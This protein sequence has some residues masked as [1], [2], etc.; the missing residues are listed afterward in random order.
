MVIGSG[1]TA[2]TMIPALAE[3]AE[4]VTMLQRSPTYIVAGPSRDDLSLKLHRHLPLG[5]AAPL[6]RWRMILRSLFYFQVARRRPQETRA[7]MLAGARA[8]L[9]PDFDVERHFAPRYN[10]WDQ[11]VCL[12]P[13]ADLFKAIK[14]GRVSV[15]TDEIERFVEDGILLKSGETLSADIIITA[16]GLRMKI[17]HGIEILVDGERVKLGNTTSYKGMMYSGIPNLASAFGYTNASWTL[18]AELICEYVCRLLNYMGRRG[19]AQCRPRLDEALFET[20]AYIDFSSGY[21]KRALKELPKQGTRRPWK[22]YQNYL[23]DLLLMRYG[24][25]NDGV[26]EFRRR[27]GTIESCSSLVKMPPPKQNDSCHRRLPN[28][29]DSCRGVTL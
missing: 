11:R 4:H 7:N 25:L 21:V 10:P 23:K 29:N 5:I 22:V 2:V 3:R 18:K 12:A 15:V 6:T 19:Y 24:R 17:M 27:Q 28:Y 1:A 26:M 13:D 20:E 14:A 16:T 8:A 9:G